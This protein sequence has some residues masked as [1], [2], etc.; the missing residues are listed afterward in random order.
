[1]LRPKRYTG[2]GSRRSR[3]VSNAF[4]PKG[5][6]QPLVGVLAE[7]M[8]V[9]AIG[10]DVLPAGSP[11]HFTKFDHCLECAGVDEMLLGRTVKTITRD[12]I[13]DWDSVFLITHEGWAYYFPALARFAVIPNIWWDRQ[14]YAFSSDLSCRRFDFFT[15]EQRFVIAALMEWIAAY[16]EQ[17]GQE[18]DLG[19]A[20]WQSWS[21]SARLW[22]SD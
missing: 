5:I 15:R 17:L 11:E 2:N 21:D 8:I 19:I 13:G 3:R 6:G 4:A 12:D 22:R 20:P 9:A 14:E 7:A 16:A 10:A 1:M 18:E